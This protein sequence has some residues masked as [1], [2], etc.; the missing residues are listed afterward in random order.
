MGGMDLA[1]SGPVEPMLGSAGPDSKHLT[2]T[3][4]LRAAIT[5]LHRWFGLVAAVWLFGIALSGSIIA[6][7]GEIDRALNPDFF[8]ASGQ[9]PVAPLLADA[10]RRHPGGEVRTVLYEHEVPGLVSLGVRTADDRRLQLYYDSGTGRLNGVRSDDNG[11]SRRALVGTVYRFH[12]S[13]LGGEALEWFLGLVAL[14]WAL[15]QLLALGI[16]F[17]SLARWRDSFRI[18]RGTHGHKRNFDLHRALSLWLYPLTLMLAVSGIYFNWPD[19]FKDTVAAVSPVTPT[20]DAVTTT[21]APVAPR[22]SMADAGGRFAA[23]AAPH[24]VTSFSYNETAGA[25]R[26]RTRDAR[27]ISDNGQRILWIS[28]QDGQVLH[29]RHETMGSA[30]DVFLAWQFPLHSGRALGLGGRALIA[31]AGLVIMTAIVTG[32]LVWAKKR[33]QR[34]RASARH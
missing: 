3:R 6:F 23:L 13:F 17:T 29:D 9:G 7:H 22:L 16:G 18:R 26:A 28:A 27:D 2:G 25:Y 4:P 21:G 8:R 30:G 19:A 5:T 24:P 20:F 31:F 12:Y 32:L 1:G 33:K 15:T 11:L 10:E 34:R 14:G